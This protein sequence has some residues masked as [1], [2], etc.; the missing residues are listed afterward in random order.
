MSEAIKVS[1]LP[2]PWDLAL[3]RAP[4]P[5]T[6]PP[7]TTGAASPKE[8]MVDGL[9]SI[10][11]NTVDNRP[12]IEAITVA[13]P[14][15]AKQ[16]QAAADAE[17]EI[18]RKKLKKMAM[19]AIRYDLRM[20]TR[21]TPFGLFSGVT[22]ARFGAHTETSATGRDQPPISTRTRIDMDWAIATAGGLRRQDEILER[23]AIERH[24][25]ARIRGSRIE[26]DTPQSTETSRAERSTGRVSIHITPLIARVLKNTSA[27]IPCGELVDTIL[28]SAP[29][30][31]REVVLHSIRSLIDS[32]ILVCSLDPP[33]NGGNPLDHL[34]S[35]RP[36]D[37]KTDPEF[38]ELAHIADLIQ[39]VDATPGD[40]RAD[41]FQQIGSRMNRLTGSPSPVHVETRINSEVS[42]PVSVQEEAARAMHWLW[43]LAPDRTGM[44]SL[45][46][47]R[48]RF[49]EKYGT[50]S[51]V[52]LL[53]VVDPAAGIGPPAGYS[54]PQYTAATDQGP[55][56]GRERIDKVMGRLLAESAEN[57]WSEIVLDD[58]TLESMARLTP[59]HPFR[60]S[61]LY[62]ELIASEGKS[63]DE[64]QFR[65][66]VG[67]NPGT[68]EAG[69]TAAR[70]LD[71]DREIDRNAQ[72]ARTRHLDGIIG[73]RPVELA[74]APRSAR[75]ANLAHTAPTIARTSFGLLREAGSDHLDPQHIVIG[76]TADRMYAIHTPTGEELLPVTGDTVSVMAQAPNAARLL[77]D[78]GFEA[79]ILWNPWNWG[80]FTSFPRLPRIRIGRVVI[81]PATWRVGALRDYLA[82]HSDQQKAVQEWRRRF[83]VPRI[84][85]LLQTDHRIDLDLEDPW[86]VLILADDVIRARADAIIEAGVDGMTSHWFSPP[87]GPPRSAEIVVSFSGPASPPARVLGVRPSCDLADRTRAR[88]WVY[89]KVLVP[90]PWQNDVLADHLPELVS[91]CRIAGA[92]RWHFLRYSDDAGPQLRVRFRPDD[93]A[94]HDVI[95]SVVEEWARSLEVMGLSAGYSF[96]AYVPEVDR[97]GGLDSIEAAEALFHA[98][99]VVALAAIAAAGYEEPVDTTT[100]T[101]V[102]L[103]TVCEAIGQVLPSAGGDRWGGDHRAGWL[104]DI[105]GDSADPT[106]RADLARWKRILDPT[107]QWQELARTPA[108]AQLRDALA[109]L[110]DAARAWA[111]TRVGRD[112]PDESV[113]NDTTV[114]SF[115]HMTCNRLLGGTMADELHVHR[116]ARLAAIAHA[117]RNQHRREE[118]VAS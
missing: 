49:L 109:P 76:A 25:L 46:E 106:A 77:W 48:Q 27:S 57:S 59:G 71:L 22:F 113:P 24:C 85:R 105:V 66:V 10:L 32:G 67:P 42:L 83:A 92:R 52:P 44:R 73:K 28:Y 50:N 8:S 15:L 18:A 36:S 70:F 63:I 68:H 30:A 88:G 100:S 41:A 104:D 110:G 99:S 19:S 6:H 54:W 114:S 116:I 62:L 117:A 45:S 23:T 13:S 60:S 97:Y 12:L 89:A 38:D 4:L 74:Y 40:D 51:L 94:D 69:S 72:E 111:F 78:L 17:F 1:P 20:R 81:A 26:L 5:P 2:S 39:R 9:V 31:S 98:D 61:E 35:H 118:D 95:R 108:A 82:G 80:P 91:A 65:L 55:T 47:Y 75:A 79:T 16:L 93:P 37:A 56:E 112:V 29:G 53:D 103:T 33:L 43:R 14:I 7:V 102:V 87:G 107:D 115:L 84:V 86:H 11:S 34:I 90:A 64:G 101:A 21:P 96:H 58:D 3:V